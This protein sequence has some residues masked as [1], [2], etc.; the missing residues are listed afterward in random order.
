MFRT[1][2]FAVLALLAGALVSVQALAQDQ[3]DSPEWP[4][5]EGKT[6]LITGSTDG[7][8]REVALRLGALGGHI[9]VHGR[10]AERGAEVVN[11]I[12]AG[13]GSAQFYRA[14]LGSLAEVRELAAAVLRDH[15]RLD[16]LINNAGIGSGTGGGERT[17][18]S[19]G[20][21]LIFQVN[22]L[23]HYLLTDLLLPRIKDSA[24]ARIINVA[25]GAQRPINFDDVMMEHSYTGGTA[26]AQSKL[27]QI[28]HTFDL[29]RELRGT[30]VTVNTL[31]PA[32]MMDTTLVRQ[33]GSPAR[34]TVDEGAGALMNLA[35]NPALTETTG[36]YFNGLNEV[37][38]NAQAYDREARAQLKA[39]SRQLTGLED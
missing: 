11:A 30:G 8:G 31:H 7:L 27:A 20:Y 24:P 19:D 33:M 37:R 39:L 34:T 17:E 10:N 9:L 4:S 12:N 29:A 38:A 6:I 28:L 13:M 14:D 2:K 16:M 3:F 21:E 5:M 1:L 35:A 32:T 36:Q 26:Y 18:S 22:Y 23:S 15:P 25:S